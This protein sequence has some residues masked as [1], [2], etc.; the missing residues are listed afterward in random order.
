MN[1]LMAESIFLKKYKIEA[2]AYKATGLVWNQL[3]DIYN[4]YELLKPELEDIAGTMSNRLMKISKVHSVRFRIKDSEHLIEKIIRKRIEKEDRVIGIENYISEITDLVG[5]RA[6]HLFKEDWESIHDMISNT[7]DL[8][9]TVK[10]YLREGDSDAYRKAFEEK[11][12]K[13]EDHKYGYRSIHY[14][15][16]T[17]PAKSE[18]FAEIQVRT[19]FEEGW[20]E[21]D[22]T[23]RYPYEID[24]FLYKEFLM[25]L[26]RL[27]GSADEMG[28]FI[29]LLRTHLEENKT[30]MLT[31]QQEIE[32]LQKIL[33][34]PNMDEDDKKEIK[35]GIASVSTLGNLDFL[36]SSLQTSYPVPNLLHINSILNRTGNNTNS[37]THSINRIQNGLS[38]FTKNINLHGGYSYPDSNKKNQSQIPEEPAIVPDPTKM[39]TKEPQNNSDKEKKN[40]SQ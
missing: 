3:E 20:S 33:D 2:V 31:K 28:T 40:N 37:Y 6:I 10:A 21:I 17:K 4:H 32:R 34:K 9:E 22:H 27:A 14:I 8:K 26:N 16:K 25:I 13:V 19:I 38:G 39:S 23:V 5:L 7:W 24:N 12:L 11:G 1:K 30:Q 15:T 35:E 18:F 29:T 36:N